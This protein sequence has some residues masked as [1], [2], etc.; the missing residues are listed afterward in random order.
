MK[1]EPLIFSIK[2]DDFDL[3]KLP[4]DGDVLRSD[5]KMLESAISE[6][7]TQHLNHLG[8]DSQISIEEDIVTVR[9]MPKS[10]LSGII[11]Y[12]I[13]LL[14]NGDYGTAVPMLRSAL[15]LSPND[16]TILFNLGMALSDLN[17]LDEAIAALKYLTQLQPNNPRAW[18]AL[19]VAY[20]RN[21]DIAA[22]ETALSTSLDLDP[23][24][25]YAYRNL[26][27]L[28]AKRSQKEGLPLLKRAAELM[29]EDQA[30][31]YGYGLALLV[32]GDSATADV[33]FKKTVDLNPLTQIAEFARSKRS[34][35]AHETM[36][37]AVDDNPRM[38]AVMYCLAALE[39]FEKQPELRKSV[40][41]EIAMLG[42]QGLDIND[43]TQKYTLKSLTGSFSGLQL[44]SYM[45]VGLRH[46]APEMDP[47]IDLS[48]E[49]KQAKQMFGQNS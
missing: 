2:I 32:T 46:L 29:P 48:R 36:R 35:L 26:G 44:V 31:Q 23:D 47:G 1:H 24:D 14:K 28:V 30:A 6:Y 17:L 41:F 13:S 8:G 9:W 15:K 39:L 42:R 19:G 4:I 22:A 21:N 25:G 43:P 7:Y 38:D 11:E 16:P 40:T 5:R 20:S 12:A 37:F 49:F 18:N 27:A 33:I 34:K 3:T 10:G 45:Y